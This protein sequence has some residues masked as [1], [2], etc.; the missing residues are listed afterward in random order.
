[1]LKSILLF[2]FIIFCIFLLSS[3]GFARWSWYH[4]IIDPQNN[5]KPSINNLLWYINKY[6][7]IGN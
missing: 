4:G 3:K 1:M 6:D 7:Y 2:Y 5:I